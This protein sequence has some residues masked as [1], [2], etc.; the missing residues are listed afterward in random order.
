MRDQL[1]KGRQELTNQVLR[2]AAHRSRVARN[3]SP[4]FV[5]R[6]DDRALPWGSNSVL[7]T[8]GWHWLLWSEVSGESAYAKL[9]SDQV[10]WFFGRNP[11]AQTYVTG[12]Y[13]SAIQHPHFRPVSSGAIELPAG[14]LAGGPNSENLAGDPT[15]AQFVQEAPMHRFVDDVE[16]FATNEV[17]INWQ[18]V[19]S[20]YLSLLVAYHDS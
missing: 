18:T 14:F 8:I 15:G 9:A 6:A 13:P 1:D 19:W 10:H 5:G 4:W 20:A 3:R 2:G 11:L 7:A 16:S 17:A 12:S